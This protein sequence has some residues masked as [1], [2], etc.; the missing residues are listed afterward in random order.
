MCP[1]KE[2]KTSTESCFTLQNAP[3]HSSFFRKSDRY[4]WLINLLLA[5]VK[6]KTT[7]EG[8]IALSKVTKNKTDSTIC[9]GKLVFNFEPAFFIVYQQLQVVLPLWLTVI[10]DLKYSL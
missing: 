7:V 5:T 1:R 10:P 2:L 4:L 9:L 8:V 6:K 3:S